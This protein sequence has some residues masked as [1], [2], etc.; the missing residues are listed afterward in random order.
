M[1][2]VVQVEV[3]W[4]CAE[5]HLE[6]RL[7]MKPRPGPSPVYS[8][9]WNSKVSCGPHAPGGV[10]K[11]SLQARLWPM[12]LCCAVPCCAVLWYAQSLSSCHAKLLCAGLFGK[13][14]GAV[15]C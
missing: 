5:A 4:K 2:Y 10:H 9:P 7:T 8:A 6:G 15:L 11:L 13:L 1:F 3:I 12:L 14:W